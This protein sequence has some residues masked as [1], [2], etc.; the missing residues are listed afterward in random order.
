MR[1]QDLEVPHRSASESVNERRDRMGR[2]RLEL[3]MTAFELPIV[4]D[5]GREEGAKSGETGFV[6]R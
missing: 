3:D 1:H 4:E 2:E 5:G 6:G